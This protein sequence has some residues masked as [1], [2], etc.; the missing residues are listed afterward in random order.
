ML[1]MYSFNID[2]NV[3]CIRCVGGSANDCIECSPDYFLYN[4]SSV[5]SVSCLTKCPSHYYPSSKECLICLDECDLCENDYSCRTC[6]L[7]LYQLEKDNIIRCVIKCPDTMPA[8]G[9][10]CGVCNETCNTCNGLSGF[11]CVTCKEYYYI[12]TFSD[13]SHICSGIPIIS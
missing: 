12:L 3:A 2:C 10:I 6:Q 5:D 4:T 1:F 9:N 8:I 11:D 7:G 13:T